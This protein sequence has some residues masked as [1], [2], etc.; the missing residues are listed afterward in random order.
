MDVDGKD[1]W[2]EFR[3][4]YHI[5]GF[6]VGNVFEVI[7]E[8]CGGLAD[9]L[10]MYGKGVPLGTDDY[11][12]D[13]GDTAGWT[14]YILGDLPE[15]FFFRDSVSI[16]HFKIVGGIAIKNRGVEC[17]LFGEV[18]LGALKYIKR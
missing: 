18:D 6:S 4:V 15:A 8:I 12:D 1:L 3:R 16:C 14:H 9:S 5:L 2:I 13:P 10:L 11:L 17:G 7:L